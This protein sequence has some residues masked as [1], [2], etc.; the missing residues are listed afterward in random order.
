MNRQLLWDD[1]RLILA[2]AANG[3]LSGAGRRLGLSHA[4]VF[5]RLGDIEGRLGVKLFDRART[6]YTP[7]LAGEEAAAAARRMESEV[8]EVERRVAGQDLRPSGSVRVTTTDTLLVGFLSPILAEFRRTYRDIHLEIAV[9]NELFS[10]SKREADAAIRPSAAPP[11]TLVG[12][13]IATIAQ[14][15]YG[16]AELVAS[17]GAEFDI[18][19]AEWVGPDE[20]MAYRALEKWMAAQDVEALCRYRLDSL[21]GMF[22]A[23]RDG[24]GL[25]VLPCY[26]GDCDDRLIRVGDTIPELSTD[27]WLLTHPDLRR[28]VRIRTLLDFVADAVK[29][30]R[31]RLAGTTPSA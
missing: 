5:R 2:I 20:R 9:S 25:A 13:R 15:V 27:L 16:G 19:S 1:L 28:T 14:A 3:S 31:P 23:V 26:L 4:T 11:E 30:H 24:A 7:T 22:A 21:F 10:L 6:G 17:Y 29:E 12:R 8:L 18:Q